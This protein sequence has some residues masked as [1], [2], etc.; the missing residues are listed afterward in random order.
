MSVS[1]FTQPTWSINCTDHNKTLKVHDNNSISTGS[2]VK[3]PTSLHREYL[4]CGGGERCFSKLTCLEDLLP[5]LL[6]PGSEAVVETV[7]SVVEVDVGDDDDDDDDDDDNAKACEAAA[8]AAA[9]GCLDASWTVSNPEHRSLADLSAA[10]LLLDCWPAPP[11]PA[12]AFGGGG[13]G[14][15]GGCPRPCL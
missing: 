5:V 14:R 6:T 1:R 8:A 13:G 10:G 4:A 12:S 2:T 9:A 15:G 3:S 11:V 7:A